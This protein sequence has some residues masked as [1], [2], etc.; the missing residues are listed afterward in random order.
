MEVLKTAY[1]RKKHLSKIKILL[2]LNRFRTNLRIFVTF[3][4][5][6]LSLVSCTSW[7]GRGGNLD[8]ESTH[9]R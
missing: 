4:A 7:K 1:L 6:F 5:C 2:L 9:H 3:V 8:G